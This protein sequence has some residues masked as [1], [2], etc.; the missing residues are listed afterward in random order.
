[1]LFIMEKCFAILIYTVYIIYSSSNESI[2]R[3]IVRMEYRHVF[4]VCRYALK[5][6]LFAGPVKSCVFSWD[7]QLF[8]SASH[9]RT[10][11][12]WSRSSTECTHILTGVFHFI[13]HH[14]IHNASSSNNQHRFCN[15]IT[16]WII[17]TKTAAMMTIVWVKRDSS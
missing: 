2:Q 14:M 3:C 5:V 1:M 7:G 13:M 11:R 12:I 17:L 15:Q 6:S 8:A 10:V 4:Y 16:D 9:D